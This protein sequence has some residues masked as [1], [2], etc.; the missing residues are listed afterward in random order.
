MPAPFCLI[1]AD[2]LR[3]PEGTPTRASHA[4]ASEYEG[5][6]GE[7][8][9][10]GSVAH[11]TACRWYGSLAVALTGDQSALVT[12]TREGPLP[13]GAPS[14]PTID[15]VIPPGEADVVVALL[16]GLVGQA[17]SQGVL[18]RRSAR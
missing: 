2:N 14:V 4:R 1:V 17:R 16:R 7:R 8:Q 11:G 12:L 9:V 3:P 15:I 13:A 5:E 6:H 18:P 10:S